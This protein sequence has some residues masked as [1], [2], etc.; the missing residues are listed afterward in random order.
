MP[1]RQKAPV[2]RTP[3]KPLIDEFNDLILDIMRDRPWSIEQRKQYNK[4]HRRIE[5]A[6]HE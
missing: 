2:D 5:A 6:S 1:P 4:V 3:A